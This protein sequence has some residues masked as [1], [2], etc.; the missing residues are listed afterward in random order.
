VEDQAPGVRRELL[1]EPVLEREGA[2]ALVREA[3]ADEV[4]G[5]TLEL[6]YRGWL[7]V[8]GR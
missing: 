8:N 2:P 5:E 6:I 3:V 4:F 7:A 1:V